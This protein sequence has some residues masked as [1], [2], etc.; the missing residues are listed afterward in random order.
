M[1]AQ[2]EAANTVQN[3]TLQSE[4]AEAML[5][6]QNMTLQ[7]EH[8]EESLFG[9]NMMLQSEHDSSAYEGYVQRSSQNMP[10][11]IWRLRLTLCNQNN[12]QNSFK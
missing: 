7:S 3:V 2:S 9:Q 11:S 5:F 6:G 8:A 1:Q 12:T 10:F 4:Q